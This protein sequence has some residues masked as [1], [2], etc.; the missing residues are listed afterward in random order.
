MSQPK[1][2]AE[3]VFTFALLSAILTGAGSIITGISGYIDNKNAAVIAGAVLSGVGTIVTGLSKVV[4][5]HYKAMYKNQATNA[6]DSAT[7]KLHLAFTGLPDGDRKPFADKVGIPLEAFADQDALKV[8]FYK[9][10]NIV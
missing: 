4:D 9:T 6:V 5:E 2:V 7:T 8:N 1:S 10:L 3:L